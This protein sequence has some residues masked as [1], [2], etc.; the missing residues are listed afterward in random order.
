[1]DKIFNKIVVLAKNLSTQNRWRKAWFSPSKTRTSIKV[2]KY[3]VFKPLDKQVSFHF[4]T[5]FIW[6]SLTIAKYFF[7]SHMHAQ[8]TAE[9]QRKQRNFSINLKGFKINFEFHIYHIFMIYIPYF[10]LFL[11][12][13]WTPPTK[14]TSGD[15]KRWVDATSN[16]I[17]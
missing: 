5:P 16:T 10:K 3:H 8:S 13:I 4:P 17:I 11:L 1:M 14:E 15:C 7:R 12:C 2:N 9:T 6:R